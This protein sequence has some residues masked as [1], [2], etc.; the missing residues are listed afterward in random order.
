M[1]RKESI[2]N[3]L[4]ADR[5]VEKLLEG[6]SIS[7]PYAADL[8]QDIYL[9]L[10]E[11]DE[12]LL[13]GLQERGEMAYYVSRMISNNIFSSTSPYYRKYERFRRM[14]CDIKEYIDYEEKRRKA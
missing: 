2:V 7:S 5:F 4:A 6:S 13:S 11:K 3:G 14:S 1:S 10:L 9:R 8:S 12:E